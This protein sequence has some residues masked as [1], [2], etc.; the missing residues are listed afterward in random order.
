MTLQSV[1]QISEIP[2]A[3][4][5]AEVETQVFLAAGDFGMALRQSPAFVRL[6]EAGAAL[7]ADDA[8]QEAIEAF[9]RRRS[10]LQFEIRLGMLEAAQRAELERLQAAMLAFPTVA[11]YLAAQSG[12]EE[13]CRETATL[14]SSEIGIDFAAN[15]RAGGCCGG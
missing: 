4:P 11:E 15:C 13:I 7:G 8:A 5:T 2:A 12:F 1:D 9:N 6:R 14:V 10:D 3:S